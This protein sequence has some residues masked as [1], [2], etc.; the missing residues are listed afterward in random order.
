MSRIVKYPIYLFLFVIVIYII[1]PIS[2]IYEN[3]IKPIFKGYKTIEYSFLKHNDEIISDDIFMF[4]HYF[5]EQTEEV[6]YL[7]D[8]GNLNNKYFD[9]IDNK[10][11]FN[12]SCMKNL[13]DRGEKFLSDDKCSWT[14][15]GHTPIVKYKRYYLVNIKEKMC[16]TFIARFN[17]YYVFNY[18]GNNLIVSNSFL[19]GKSLFNPIKFYKINKDSF[20]IVTEGCA[21]GADSCRGQR[22]DWM[23]I[24]FLN[25]K[26]S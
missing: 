25:E 26:Y 9:C 20:S 13:K 2:D 24:K 5:S 15:F 10:I 1:T 11:K 12:I 21:H 19:P 18:D 23:E 3:E 14:F 17:S 7:T 4:I 22:A 16:G 8:Y 6:Y